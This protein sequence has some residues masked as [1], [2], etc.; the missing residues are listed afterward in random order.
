MRLLY[1]AF[2]VP[3]PAHKAEVCCVQ[4]WR[5]WLEGK[6]VCL[7][8]NLDLQMFGECLLESPCQSVQQLPDR[9][10]ETL[11]EKQQTTESASLVL[12]FVGD[13]YYLSFSFFPIHVIPIGDAYTKRTCLRRCA[14]TLVY[15]LWFLIH[16]L[17]FHLN[18]FKTC[19]DV[20]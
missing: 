4:S 13:I 16:D 3:N 18:T 19:L 8:F 6:R 12:T 20:L 1:F 9:S 11:P 7:G 10:V 5:L 14:Q 2:V 17:D 15:K